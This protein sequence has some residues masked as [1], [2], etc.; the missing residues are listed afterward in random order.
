MNPKLTALLAVVGAVGVAV[1]YVPKPGIQIADLV[2]AGIQTDCVHKDLKV[3][4]SGDD[5]AD[6]G[7][8][9]KK[10]DVAVCN[11]LDGGKSVIVPRRFARVV[12]DSLWTGQPT[13]STLPAD[14]EADVAF[15]CACSRPDAGAC[16][17][18]SD[19]GPSL[20]GVTL[21][22]G[23]WGGVGCVPKPCV[24]W[25]GRSSWPGECPLQ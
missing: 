24:E 14:G 6:G 19:G 16:L 1:I 8:C 20:I 9:R 3:Q 2:D 5:C 12:A 18:T 10:I 11:E 25:F 13:A 4:L 22:P 23:A 15:D 21:N 17:Q 7:Y